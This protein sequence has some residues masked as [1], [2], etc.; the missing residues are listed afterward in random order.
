MTRK[1]YLVAG[2]NYETEEITYGVFSEDRPTS[3]GKVILSTVIA[4][5]GEDYDQ[6]LKNMG[7]FLDNIPWGDFVRERLSRPL[8]HT[9]ALEAMKEAINAG[10]TEK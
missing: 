3:S 1:A 9:P 6:A 4:V 2:H 7:R 10:K 5:E 8:P